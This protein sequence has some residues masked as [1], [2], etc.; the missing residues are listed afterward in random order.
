MRVEERLERKCTDA[1]INGGWL[2]YKLDQRGGPRG[3]PDRAFWGYGGRH[4]IVE[5]KPPGWTPP[6]GEDLQTEMRR[7]FEDRGFEVH[8]IQDYASFVDLFNLKE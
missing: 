6:K 2:I 1:A 8:I 3:W 7:E 4:L 5:F